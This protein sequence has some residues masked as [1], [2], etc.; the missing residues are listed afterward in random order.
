MRFSLK[1][2]VKEGSRGKRPL[3]MSELRRSEL[4]KRRMNRRFHGVKNLI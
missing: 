1:M 2:A 4:R 3:S